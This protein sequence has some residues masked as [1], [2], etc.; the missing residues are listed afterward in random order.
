MARRITTVRLP[1]PDID[2]IQEKVKRLPRCYFV[3]DDLRME[4]ALKYMNVWLEA[5]TVFSV[6]QAFYPVLSDGGRK[7]LDKRMRA[8]FEQCRTDFTTYQREKKKREKEKMQK[9][10]GSKKVQKEESIAEITEKK[11][12]RSA[13][14]FTLQWTD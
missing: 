2:Q 8:K 12:I 3:D 13:D 11:I 14:G 10:R 5:F 1:T 6:I 9:P 4:N 7:E